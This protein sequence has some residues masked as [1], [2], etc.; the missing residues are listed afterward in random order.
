L[1]D[2]AFGVLVGE[3][4]RPFATDTTDIVASSESGFR[5]IDHLLGASRVVVIDTVQTGTVDPGTLFTLKL[6]DLCVA[7]GVSPHYVG[8]SETLA[9]ARL[10]DLPVA[11]E[12]I[13]VAVE[14]S[15][16]ISVGGVMNEDVRAAIPRVV[17]FAAEF[18]T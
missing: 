11:D 4:L 8:L 15:D 3:E 9:L 7:N 1:A 10:L 18:I 12:L 16:C 6:D 14:A 2:D 17:E 5:L 13:V